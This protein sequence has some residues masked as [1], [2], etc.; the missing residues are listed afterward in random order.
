M[1]QAPGN[2]GSNDPTAESARRQ[3][4]MMLSGSTPRVPLRELPRPSQPNAA[5]VD[6]PGRGGG[7]E[8][9]PPGRR[10]FV[11]S[12]NDDKHDNPP[13]GPQRPRRALRTVAS[14]RRPTTK[15]E[16][17]QKRPLGRVALG[18]V[19]GNIIRLPKR[20]ATE[21]LDPDPDVVA[22]RRALRAVIIQRAWRSYVRR[23][24]SNAPAIAAPSPKA[25]KEWACEVIAR[26]WR[27]V[28]TSKVPAQNK[29]I[30]QIDQTGQIN[31][32]TYPEYAEQMK[33]VEQKPR[34]KPAGQRPSIRQVDGLRR[35]RRL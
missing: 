15:T 18:E 6:V 33:Q 9:M 8:N 27:Q 2:P 28:K 7:K 24:E 22:L 25:S 26:W 19:H 4:R 14:T 5:Q 3:P 20:Q 21:T 35:I 30:Q 16:K 17:G 31:Q 29:Q 1:S 10:R 12:G 32:T 23:R 11:H 13:R 34:Q